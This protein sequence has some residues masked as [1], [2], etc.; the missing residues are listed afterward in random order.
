MVQS[1]ALG[2]ES[3]S[4][5]TA[6]GERRWFIGYGITAF[7]YRI[8]LS[9]GICL[10]VA[11]EYL[12]FGVALAAWAAS[13]QLLLPIGRGL[14]FMLTDPRLR[15]RRLRAYSASAAAM[16]AALCF[17][18]LIEFPHVTQVRGVVWPVDEAIVRAETEC[19]LDDILMSNGS[20]VVP[21]DVL[22]HCDTELLSSELTIL[23]AEHAAAQAAL[24]ATRDRV[25]RGLAQSELDTAEQMLANAQRN[26]ARTDLVSHS[27][28]TLYLPDSENLEGNYF[29]QGALLGYV[30]NESN[31]SIRTMLAQERVNLLGDRLG[32]VEIVRLRSTDEPLPSKV[33]RRVP[34]ATNTLV[35]PALGI[36]G[37]GDLLVAADASNVSRLK[38]AAFELEIE[39]PAELR[40]SLIGEPIQVRFDHGSESLAALA[41]RQVQLLL[42][43]R[44]NV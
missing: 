27:T 10:F 42:L 3:S 14:K 17:L 6:P 33:I 29:E 37:G 41:Y 7:I 4:P 2:L 25:Q 44:F 12:F 32:D 18:F 21:G 40:Q 39:L 43:R 24:Y 15:E 20:Q 9:I 38:Q 8:T 34:A 30:L 31:V 1:Y 26:L 28:G 11:S 22:L 35:S 23:R 13:T 19:F 36:D 16:A 5:V